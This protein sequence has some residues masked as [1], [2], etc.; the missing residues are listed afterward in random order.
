MPGGRARPVGVVIGQ[1]G[2]DRVPTGL[3]GRARILAN[4]RQP[5]AHRRLFIAAD[6]LMVKRGPVP[7]VVSP[8]QVGDQ[9][10]E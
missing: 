5:V 4:Q 3:A 2:D 7:V 6:E 9:L 10:H 8:C 1:G